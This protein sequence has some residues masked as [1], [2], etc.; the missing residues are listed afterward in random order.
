MP[1]ILAVA[2][3]GT[4]ISTAMTGSSSTGEHCGRPS[5]MAMRPAW[6]KAMSDEFDGVIGAVDQA[7]RDVHHLEAERARMQIVAHAD[8]DARDVVLRHHAAGDLV[9]ELEALP[10]RAAA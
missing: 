6:R 10:A 5:L 2:S 7:D 1:L 8:L 3:D 9:G 4:A